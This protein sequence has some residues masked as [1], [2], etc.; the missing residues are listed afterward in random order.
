M[1]N[2]AKA[3]R[4]IQLVLICASL[5][6]GIAFPALADECPTNTGLMSTPMGAR[7]TEDPSCVI[8]GETH[9]LEWKSPAPAKI[10]VVCMHGLGLC[11]RAY[12]PLGKELSAAGIDGFGVN[13]RGFGPDRDKPD[14]AKLDCVET[15]GDVS[16]LLTNIHKEYPDYKVFLIGESM[17]GAL[18]IRIAAENPALVDGVV[19]SAP[20]WKLLKMR[21]TAVKGVFELFLFPGS[22]PG[23]AGRA[24]MHQA[25]TD[26][27]L[28]EHWLTD[29]S[30]KLKLS[31]K[32]ATSFLRFISRTD[33]YAKQLTKPVLV[34]QGLDDHLVSPKAV[35]KLFRDIPSDNKTF[36][37]DGKGEHLVLEEARFSPPLVEKLIGWM[38]TDV[39]DQSI[40]AVTEVVNDQTLSPQE[41]RRLQTLRRLAKT[42]YAVKLAGALRNVHQ[43]LD[44]RGKIDLAP[45][46]ELPHLYAVGPLED[47]RGEVTIWNGKP[48]ISRISNGTLKVDNVLTGKA[49][50]LVYGQAPHWKRIRIGSSL[51]LTEVDDVIKRE[52]T[53]CGINT[54]RPFPFLIDGTAK[55]ARY[56]VMNRTDSTPPTPG[57]AAHEKA[58]VHFTMENAPVQLLG[59]YSEHHQGIFTHH[60]SFVHMHI[61]TQDDKIAGHLEDLQ[62]EP[63]AR[64]QLPREYVN[65]RSVKTGKKENKK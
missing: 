32:E 34:V 55:Y 44:F 14:R 10:V 49:C 37:I 21:R 36:L 3:N 5:G 42:K 59:F 41:K 46:A 2:K 18:A 50:F 33:T 26:P 1:A 6:L 62:L 56:H 31:F 7:C 65:T 16:K 13:V 27:E 35:A 63:G 12:K 28:T 38:K 29:P 4:F 30:H 23:P 24:V 52:A 64:L 48:L 40:P 47:L 60:S 15:V 22:H 61:K 53:K 25:T 39:T 8:V 58:K 17:G 45:L 19:C 9:M 43:G 11:A 54:D 57:P 51:T 20:A